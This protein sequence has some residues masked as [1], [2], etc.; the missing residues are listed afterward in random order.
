MP[1]IIECTYCKKKSKRFPSQVSSGKMFCNTSCCHKYT[2]GNKNPNWKGGLVDKTCVIC[3]KVFQVKISHVGYRKTCSKK[4]MGVY[5]SVTRKGQNRK[6]RTKYCIVCDEELEIKLSHAD[7]H[8]I[9]CSYECMAEDYKTRLSGYKNPHWKGGMVKKKCE[10]CK[11]VYLVYPSLVDKRRFCSISCAAV[12]RIK[13]TMPEYGRRSRSGKRKDLND[14]YVRSSWEANYARYLNWLVSIN[15]IKKWEYEPDEF[16]F[17]NIKRGTRFYIPDFK[18]F[19]NDGSIEY[20][21]VKGYMDK[22]SITK[23]KR[24]TKY[25]PEIKVIIIDRDVYYAIARQIKNLIP[26]WERA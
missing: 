26:N 3:N 6:R 7:N 8:G 1:V 10:S 14:L 24:M 17:K 18:I 5:Q 23:L 13:N 20:H 15:E 16:E 19:N 12:W 4:C 2:V 9:Y 21:E 22:K 11:K 25:Y